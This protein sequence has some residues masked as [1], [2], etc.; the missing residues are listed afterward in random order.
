MKKNWIVAVI[1][2]IL[3][4]CTLCAC[5]SASV[6][7][8]K[9]NWTTVEEET[10]QATCTSN[11]QITQ[12]CTN[13]RVKKTTVAPKLGHAYGSWTSN[14]DF[15]HS[16]VCK[17]NPNHVETDN[18]TGIVV[19]GDCILCCDDSIPNPNN[20]NHD[21]SD[22]NYNGENGHFRTCRNC[23]FSMETEDC[24]IIDA[25]CENPSICE[26]CGHRY[27]GALGHDWDNWTA[28]G[29]HHER[30]CKTDSTHIQTADHAD[31]DDDNLC[32]DCGCVYIDTELPQDPVHIWSQWT[33]NNDGTHTRT[34]VACTESHDETADCHGGE[35]DCLNGATCVDCNA[36]YTDAL[37]HS[38]PENWTNNGEN[39]IKVCA[40]GCGVDLT[41]EH[42]Y[43]N[44]GFD[45]PDCENDGWY[46][47]TCRTCGDQYVEPVYTNGHDW[48][49]WTSNE[50]GTHTRV[51]ANNEHHTET[52]D[53]N[54]VVIEDVKVDCEVDGYTVY[55]CDG[56]AHSYRVDGEKALG[57][58]YGEW[59]S[60]GDGKRK[61]ICANNESHTITENFIPNTSVDVS[62]GTKLLFYVAEDLIEDLSAVRIEFVKPKYNADGT[63]AEEIVT[64]CT[65]YT[66][67]VNKVSGQKLLRFVYDDIS[68][69]E[70]SV[71]IVANVY[72][73][74]E[75]LSSRAYSIKEYAM[76]FL[77]ATPSSN[78][79]E[80]KLRTLLVDMLNYG[81]AAQI[82]FNYNTDNLANADLTEEQKAYGTQTN[83][84]INANDNMVRNPDGL[85]ELKGTSVSATSIIRLN[86]G[87]ALKD[88][89]IEDVEVVF[90]YTDIR[91]VAQQYVVDGTDISW[92]QLSED[93][94]R[95]SVAFDK[96][97][98]TQLRDEFTISFRNKT[99][100][101]QIGD[102]CT[103]SVEAN[104][105]GLL[106]EEDDQE[107]IDLIYAMMKYGDSAE[108]YFAK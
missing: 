55:Q 91:G 102:S 29:D 25:D 42:A 43:S 107:L 28:A 89:N 3:L 63:V 38:Y 98:T 4:A 32:D 52:E 99:T 61:K 105:T 81:A 77:N 6:R 19:N 11:G 85:I 44:T 5:A 103:T 41:E 74:D 82:Y 23:L 104:L 26:V 57:H 88:V 13:C 17:N 83:P 50:D 65:N 108:T 79:T 14:D 92:Y 67:Y 84:E 58:D 36:V 86:F 70:M 75:F 101:E 78:A 18:H 76:K 69:N 37:G 53:C 7:C 8:A 51:C 9:H 24:S 35:A 47:Y 10:I 34:C 100:G 72:S 49:D 106:S 97:G 30:V 64:K 71:E 90:D 96:Y 80:T 12:V 16:R 95:Y 66:N 21:W 62:N 22:W 56:C 46:E 45:F 59:I 73:G 33:S 40:N 2:I 39:H 60:T 68:S 1:L 15:T 20:C 93:E 31:I 54:Y 27:E 94:I 48:S 87:F